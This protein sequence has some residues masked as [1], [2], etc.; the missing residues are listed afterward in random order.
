MSKRKTRR[1][2]A[3]KP[4]ARKPAR[5]AAR[6][7]ATPA[8]KPTPR[9]P[10]KARRPQATAPKRPMLTPQEAHGMRVLKQ[11]ADDQ[12]CSDGKIA[13]ASQFVKSLTDAERAALNAA[14]DRLKKTV[15][16]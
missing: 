12:F 1:K 15:G 3:K 5:K 9:K 13:H 11:L 10:R 2:T 16:A 8:R 7:P 6:K 14:R 4:A